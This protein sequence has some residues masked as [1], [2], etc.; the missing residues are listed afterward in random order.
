M[1]IVSGVRRIGFLH[2]V[3]PIEAD[4]AAMRFNFQCSACCW[5]FHWSA[6]FAVRNE[7]NLLFPYWNQAT[8]WLSRN[9][10]TISGNRKKLFRDLLVAIGEYQRGVAPRRQ[11]LE[12][13]ESGNEFIG[14]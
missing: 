9:G 4:S 14:D 6:I 13:W 8:S 7:H 12:L 3:V 1:L 11:I 2:Q 5:S 10:V